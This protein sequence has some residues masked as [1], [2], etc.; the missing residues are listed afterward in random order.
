MS[1]ATLA[2][3]MQNALRNGTPAVSR[4]LRRGLIIIY[5]RDNPERPDE[6]RLA[7]GRKEIN[8]SPA[9]WEIIAQYFPVPAGDSPTFTRR[10]GVNVLELTWI[11]L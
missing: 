7:I 1:M 6:Y 5:A 4:N 9:E 2:A 10:N 11:Q 3:E 8:P